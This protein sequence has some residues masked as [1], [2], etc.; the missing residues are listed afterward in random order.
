[1]PIHIF[2]HKQNTLFNIFKDF[3]AYDLRAN[4]HFQLAFPVSSLRQ[5][6]NIFIGEPKPRAH[7]VI[8]SCSLCFI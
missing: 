4:K 3:I 6:V 5:G 7:R 2:T 1:M 8:T